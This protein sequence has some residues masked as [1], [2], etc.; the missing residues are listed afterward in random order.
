MAILSE[1][2]FASVARTHIGNPVQTKRRKMVDRINEQL[3][4]LSAYQRGE[5]YTRTVNR[6]VRDL[7]TDR[8]TVETLTR[9][10][11]PWWWTDKDGKLYMTVR[12]GTRVLE[13]A[14]G[15]PAIEVRDVEHIGEIL[16]KLRDAVIQGELDTVLAQ[17]GD[18]CWRRPKSEPL[19]RVA[20]TQN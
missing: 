18:Q 10:V 6:A 1:L 13:L 17:A 4:T 20:P 11:S 14:K 5:S 8:Q 15:K 9:R 12:Y 7:E 3:A 16:V 19:I 2:K